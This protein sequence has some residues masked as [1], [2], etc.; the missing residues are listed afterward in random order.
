[1]DNLLRKQIGQ[2][3]KAL[4]HQ[5]GWSQEK[6]AVHVGCS[7]RAIQRWERG[8]VTPQWGNIEN[9]AKAFGVDPAQIV[10]QE[11]IPGLQDDSLD[12][13]V[14]KLALQLAALQAQVDQLARSQRDQGEGVAI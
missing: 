8:A 2:R 3:I 12:T 5:K 13:R 4:R 9:L 6:A 11:S 10:G 1:M 14:S 7:W